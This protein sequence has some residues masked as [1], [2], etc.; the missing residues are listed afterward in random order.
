MSVRLY[1]ITPTRFQIDVSSKSGR[2][3][4]HIRGDI[5]VA[6]LYRRK[7][8]ELEGLDGRDLVEYLREKKARERAPKPKPIVYKTVRE[9][10]TAWVDRCE[11]VG[12]IEGGTAKAYRSASACWTY[13]RV[14]S[15]KVNEVTLAMLGRVLDDARAAG[16][17]LSTL[18]SILNPLA[19]YFEREVKEGRLTVDPCAGI[20]DYLPRPAPPKVIFFTREQ[21]L[22]ILEACRT[23]LPRWHAALVVAFGCGLRWG[24]LVCVTREKI[25]FKRGVIVVDR[26]FGEKTNKVGPTK[27]HKAREVAMP[28]EVADVLR[29]HL[30]AVELEGQVNG[31]S[32]EARQ[33][34]F[35]NTLGKIQHRTPF[36]LTWR[37]VIR[38]ANVPF[39]NFHSTRH[40]FATWHLA[41]GTDVRWLSKQMGHHSTK[42][43][44][45]VYGHLIPEQH[46]KAA[47]RLNG[48][49]TAK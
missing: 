35:P 43:T 8:E 30:E 45:D 41:A 16:R 36:Y 42:I 15:V 29:A 18:K 13:P 48:Y 11:R 25:D 4:E 2:M 32:V 6:E 39:R 10:L 40:S 33:L 19:S 23:I 27:N 9:S 5:H 37:R 34:V 21:S 26:S 17:S 7:L 38:A 24:E 49:L 44:W 14:G 12:D 46:A 28:S 1:Q 47:D 31:W 22:K 3:R 20:A